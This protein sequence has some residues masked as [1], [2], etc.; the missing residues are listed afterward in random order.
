M[1]EGSVDE[2]AE[3]GIVELTDIHTRLSV[4][5]H[6][7]SGQ[8]VRLWRRTEDARMIDR[9][10]EYR[11]LGD[12]VSKLTHDLASLCDRIGEKINEKVAQEAS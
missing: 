10:P 11:E 6:L 9:A 8:Y 5:L 2:Y 7:L 1:A 12:E 3:P 4:A